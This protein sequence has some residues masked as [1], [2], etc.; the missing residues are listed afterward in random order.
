MSSPPSSGESFPPFPSSDGAASFPSSEDHRLHRYLHGKT[1]NTANLEEEE[2]DF[3]AVMTPV[4]GGLDARL[5]CLYSV[6]VIY[7]ILSSRVP[8]SRGPVVT[9]QRVMLTPHGRGG[10]SSSSSSSSGGFKKARPCA[11]FE[12]ARGSFS[13]PTTAARRR[14]SR[15]GGGTDQQAGTVWHCKFYSPIYRRFIDLYERQHELMLRGGGSVAAQEGVAQQHELMPLPNPQDWIV[16]FM[17]L[18][19]GVHLVVSDYAFWAARVAIVTCGE[20]MLAMVTAAPPEFVA[21]AQPPHRYHD[22]ETAPCSVER[23]EEEEAVAADREQYRELLQYWVPTLQ[24][25]IRVPS[26][27]SA[28]PQFSIWR[29]IAWELKATETILRSSPKNFQ[30]W[31][32]RFVLL[33]AAMREAVRDMGMEVGA[34]AAAAPSWKGSQEQF[35]AYLVQRHHP[36]LSFSIHFDDRSLIDFALVT[37]A[38]NYHCWIYRHDLL[39]M[40]PFLAA[41]PSAF[42]DLPRW[43]SPDGGSDGAQAAATAAGWLLPP[44]PLQEELNNT[45][46]LLQEDVMNNSAWS[47]RFNCVLYRLLIPLVRQFFAERQR[48]NISLD[49]LH[50][51]VRQVLRRELDFALSKLSGQYVCNEASLSHLHGIAVLYQ[52]FC[53]RLHRSEAELRALRPDVAEAV[54]THTGGLEGAAEVHSR[55]L[56]HRWQSPEAAPDGSSSSSQS[57]TVETEVWRPDRDIPS[58]PW[59]TYRESFLLMLYLNDRLTLLVPGVEDAKRTVLEALEHPEEEDVM[60]ELRQQFPCQMLV[61]S[62]HHIDAARFQIRRY[63]LEQCWRLYAT[64]SD[65]D[66]IRA[67]RPTEVYAEQ[68][69]SEDMLLPTDHHENVNGSGSGFARLPEAFFLAHE[70]EALRLGK[71]LYANDPIRVKYWRHEI[72]QILL[73]RYDL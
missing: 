18:A 42:Q 29:S 58:I 16:W 9:G 50:D 57:G 33:S 41:I 53:C 10:S 48:S 59:A 17:T 32:H 39:D 52:S 49:M 25:I 36:E 34:G 68:G 11:S 3:A 43:Y 26:P 24:D 40:F 63:M 1:D 66:A 22:P 23:G 70:A 60:E 6:R 7:R 21:D 67:A 69:V 14:S 5:R 31:T 62:L 35:D 54:L 13:S 27:T 12:R 8:P 15:G 71:V 20:R 19:F 55:Q 56:Y 30:V 73:R 44:C 4:T 45:A 65:R 51:V 46:R 64:D 72:T 38:K 2:D 37:N 61:D 47:H 28:P